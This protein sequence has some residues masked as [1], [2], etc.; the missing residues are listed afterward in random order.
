MVAVRVSGPVAVKALTGAKE[1]LVS[2]EPSTASKS[3]TT[4]AASSGSPSLKV[5][6]GRSVMVQSL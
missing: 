1:F 3:V 5:M 2:A 6:F 4:A